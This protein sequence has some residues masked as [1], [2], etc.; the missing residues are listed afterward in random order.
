MN[1]K[2]KSFKIPHTMVILAFVAFLMAIFGSS[3]VC[4]KKKIV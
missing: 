3:S 4:V 1:I 2:N